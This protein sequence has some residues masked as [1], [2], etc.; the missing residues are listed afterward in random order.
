MEFDPAIELYLDDQDKAVGPAFMGAIK[1]SG[2]KQL[3]WEFGV[4]FGL[5]TT[6]PTTSLRGGV[7]LEF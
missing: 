1:L 7:E 4:L 6:T 5:D 3:R 2:R